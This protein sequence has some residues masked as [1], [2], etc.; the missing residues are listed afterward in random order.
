MTQQA[1]FILNVI[2]AQ[3]IFGVRHTTAVLETALPI[4]M[5]PDSIL[6]I[7]INVCVEQLHKVME[8]RTILGIQH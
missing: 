1:H 6:L 3:I 8:T 2:V 7:Q 4:C 5:L